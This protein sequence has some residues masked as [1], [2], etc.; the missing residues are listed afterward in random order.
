TFRLASTN[1]GFIAVEG[2]NQAGAIRVVDIGIPSAYVDAIES[3]TLLLTRD[4]AFQSL[5]E[6]PPSSHK[7]TFGH[8]GIIAGSVGKTGAAALAAR[9]ALRVGAG[10]VTVATP[11]SV[12]EGLEA[13]LLEAMTMPL[14]E[15]K[16]RTLA[17]S[18]LDR[19]LAFMQAR[20]AIAI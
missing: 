15:T 4:S 16:A 3:R 1:L 11:S 20:T 9:A 13:K 7:G 17:R 14:P 8:A 5:P 6:R 2:I 18:G 19:I 12:N 10:L